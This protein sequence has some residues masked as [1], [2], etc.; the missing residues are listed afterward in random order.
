MTSRNW[1]HR[2]RGGIALAVLVL[3]ALT[4]PNLLVGSDPGPAVLTGVI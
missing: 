2:N 1:W 4:L 3:L